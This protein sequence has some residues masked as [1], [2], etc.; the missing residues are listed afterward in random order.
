[1]KTLS[2]TCCLAVMVLGLLCFPAHG[3]DYQSGFSFIQ[4]PDPLS[5]DNLTYPLIA[6]S[7]PTVGE[8]FYDPRFQ[9]VLS[10]VTQ[11]DGISGR[12]EYSRFD[13]FNCDQSLVILL[14]GG[15]ADWRVYRTQTLPYNQNANLVITLPGINEPRWDPTD[16]QVIWYL[17][18]FRIVTVNVSTGE[19]V[20]RKDF[21]SDPTIGPIIAAET[22]LYRI[23]TKDEGESSSDKRYWALFLQ[24][25]QDD[26]RVRYVFTWDR[27]SDR[28]LG[29][30]HIPIQEAGID[31]VGMSPKG[32]W[33][34]IG[35]DWDNGGNLAGLT[36]ANKELTRFHRLDYTTAHSDV[37]LDSEGNEVIVMQNVVTDHI[38]LIPIALTT[39]PI[40]AAGGSYAH[41]NRTPL[42]RLF[43]DSQSPLGLNSGVHISANVS[44]YCVVS[45]Y[46]QQGLPEQNWLDRTITLVRLDR[47]NPR[48]F[49]LAKVYN[50][51][52]SY[53][54]ETHA[55]I[56]NDGSKVVWAS[57][58]DQNVGSEQVFLMQ[59]NM[60]SNWKELTAGKRLLYFP[61]IAS[62]SVWETEIALINSSA[63]ETV[64]GELRAANDNGQEVTTGVSTIT[65]APYA[66]RQITVG[67]ELSNS[68]Q[69]GSMV[70]ESD[71]GAIRGYTKFYQNGIYRVA[72]PAVRSINTGDLY[73]THIASNADWWTGLS[74]LNTTTR[75]TQVTIEF[76]N[77]TSRTVALAANEHTRFMVE[78]L[79]G[80]QSQTDIHSA[81]IRNA[82]GVIGLELFGNTAAQ[83]SR[84]L[85]GI[86]LTD[87]TTTTLYYPHVASD[88]T[89]WT[90]IVAYNPGVAAT[91]LTI[92]PYGVAGSALASTTQTI[93]GGQ[94]YLGT[95]EQLGLPTE[96]AWLRIDASN[97]LTG[98][99]LIGTRDL[100]KL[101]AYCTPSGGAREAVL[102][103]LEKQGSTHIALVNLEQ[104]PATVTL[105]AYNDNGMQIASVTLTISGYGKVMDTAETLLGRSLTGATYLAY[106]AD[107]NLLSYQLNTSSNNTLLDGL[108][109]L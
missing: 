106:S 70:F 28:V 52:G 90:G 72:V 66:R 41:T 37:G 20:I 95:A 108:P 104:T 51:T 100:N 47:D 80:G 15:T 1:M 8:S 5:G 11:A 31:W 53:W 16:P 39:Q 76:D 73:V 74:L 29:V 91:T 10:R 12:H 27:Q 43:Y 78:S 99:E 85:E 17:R 88:A 92:H 24:G 71:S 34:L 93:N 61:H 57:N 30:Y 23:T 21:S 101:A 33:V 26:Y 97:A 19:E 14:F 25:A 77:D 82:S 4:V 56:T 59:L 6:R 107:K 49:Y 36:M 13:P 9:T 89:W 63:T 48:V 86:L 69:I 46:I 42:I 44:G 40:L 55:A 105:T 79:F 62:N 67:S 22:D 64:T 50:T 7:V 75:A 103:K 68:V 32:N 87:D 81:V 54:E 58:W 2:I 38:D 83:T 84:C 18:D 3:L 94:K 45:T 98:F 102:P 35:G 60:P 109:G 96:T 65:L